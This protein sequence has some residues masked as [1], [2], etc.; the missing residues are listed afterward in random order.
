LSQSTAWTQQE[1][2]AL[3]LRV[4]ADTLPAYVA[5]V[6]P[7]L[8]YAMANRMYVEQFRRDGREIVGR[9]VA[10]VLGSSFEN[11]AWRLRAALRGEAQ[12][13]ESPM[14]T[15][16]GDRYLLVR[17]IPDRDV[18]GRVRGVIVHGIDITER[19]RGEQV[20]LETEKL[21]AVGRLASSI[22]HEINNPLESVVNLVY[23]IETTAMTDPEQSVRYAQLAQQELARV[24]QIATQ[25]LRFFKQSTKPKLADIAELVDSVLTLYSGRL[26]NSGVTVERRFEAGTEIVCFEGEVR[27]VLNNLVSNALDAMRLGGRLLVRTRRVFDRQRGRTGCRITIADTGV[28]MSTETLGRLY[29]AFFTTKGISGTGL[30]LWVSS[31]IVKKHGGRLTVKSSASGKWRG[32]V[33]VVYLPALPE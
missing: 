29:E 30:G 13:F 3:R 5:Y 17:H 19:K 4:I 32:T 33:F 22:A 24:S 2:D 12:L 20:L 18:D 1:Q 23:L 27:Q 9:T 10:E 25:T 26:T 31:G 21:A 7:E 8:R 15:V 28:G 14:R 16:E 11:I 6:D